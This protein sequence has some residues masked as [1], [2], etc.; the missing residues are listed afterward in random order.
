MRSLLEYLVKSIVQKPKEV[1]VEEKKEGEV[2]N[3]TLSVAKEDM[4]VVIGKQGKIIQALRTVLRIPAVAQ[5]LKVNLQLQENF[6][7]RRD[8]SVPKK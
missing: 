6:K 1:K 5:N 7:D 2:V 3:L 4:G 8:L